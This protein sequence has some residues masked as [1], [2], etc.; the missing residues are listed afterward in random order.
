M[1]HDDKTPSAEA[2][3]EMLEEVAGK[4]GYLLPHHGLLAITDPDLL[5]GYDA[6]YSALTL[7][8]RRLAED[9]KEF[10][11]L[12]VLTTCDEAL[13]SQHL[14]KFRA[15]GGSDAEVEAAAHLAALGEGSQ[16][17]GFL[18]DHWAHHLPN[19]DQKR[20]YMEAVGAV[21]DRFA[22]PTHRVHMGLAAVHTCHLQ[23]RELRWHIAEAYAADIPEPSL[24]E[25][26]SYTMFTGSIPKYI[27]G[28]EVWRDMIRDNAVAASEPFKLWASMNTDGFG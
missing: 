15:A 10:V 24:A 13:A 22:I 2:A 9:D 14:A 25:A 3:K 4:R 19:Y 8:P 23:W 21:Q 11:W 1:T 28:C 17:Y 20:V 6:C 12:C 16:A 5:A 18:A 27:E 7:T 26:L